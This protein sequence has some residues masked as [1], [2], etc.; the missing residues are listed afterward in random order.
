M[1]FYSKGDVVTYLIPYAKTISY[2]NILTINLGLITENNRVKNRN[3]K[4]P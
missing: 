2:Y 4:Q 3:Q 1:C